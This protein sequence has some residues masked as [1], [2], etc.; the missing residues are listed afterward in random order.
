[1]DVKVI[2]LF[3]KGQVKVPPSKS[4]AH[5]ALICAALSGG[6]AAI[7]NIQLSKDI[8]ATLNCITALGAEYQIKDDTIYMRTGFTKK[9]GDKCVLD[10]NES[11]STLRFFIPIALALG[12]DADFIGAKRLFERPLTP[13]LECFKDKNITISKIENGVNVTG[14]LTADSYQ[15]KGNVSSQFIT[16]LL[17]ALP[18]LQQKSEIVITTNLESKGYVDLTLN[19][20]QKFG[21]EIKNNNYNSFEI[22][23]QKYIA[24]NTKVEGDYS[25]AAFMLVAAAL[26]CDIKIDG[27]SK[28]SLQ[29]DKKILDILQMAGADVEFDQNDIVSVTVQNKLTAFDI[30]VNEIPDLVPPIAVLMAF[31][32]GTSHILNASRLRIK[33][34]DRLNTVYLEL[35]KLGVIITENQDSLEITGQKTLIGGYCTGHNDHRIA[36]MCAVA[37]I[38]CK[39]RVNIQDYK[40]VDKSYPTFFEDFC[41]YKYFNQDK[42][43]VTNKNIVLIGLPG[44]GKTTIGRQIAKQFNMKFVDVDALIET[45]Q[46]IKIPQIFE[47]YGEEYFR[48]IEQKCVKMVSSQTNTVISTGGGVVTK[49]Q[50]MQYL[51]ENGIIIFIDRKA[52]DIANDIKTDNRPLMQNNENRIFE[53]ENQRRD[54]YLK[55]SNYV[56]ESEPSRNATDK[57]MFELIN[58]IKKPKR[59]YVIGDPIAHSLSPQIHTPVLQKFYNDASY[60]KCYVSK[61]SL[62][63][64]V[65]MVKQNNIKGFNIT[66]PHKAEIIKYLDTVDMAAQALNSVNT[67]VNTNG[68]L[69]GY[70]TDGKGFFT[71]LSDIGFLVQDKTVV[72]IGAGGAS[73]AV[74]DQAAREKAKQI[75]ILARKIGQAQA[76]EK[77]LSSIHTC[78]KIKPVQLDSES[79][80]K[81]CE[82][83]DLLINATSL[84]MHGTN[85]QFED[86][87]F[88]KQLPKTSVVADLI[89]KPDK[90]LFLQTAEKQGLKIMNG[91][92]MLIYQALIA[93]KYYTGQEIDFETMQ[94]VV[95]QNLKN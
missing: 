18:L 27:L 29:G 1:M 34:S 63:N 84:G 60:E 65:Y 50:N 22:Q 80:N 62:E 38:K 61:N 94:Q 28:A 45:T 79:L 52:K 83:A 82:K 55:Y 14:N 46:N 6:G 72:V 81:Y 95:K 88:I 17:F 71:A 11:G 85:A 37:A 53:L 68:K 15:I 9:N 35:S 39:S 77:T 16:G 51:A 8:L 47:K 59:Y 75:I 66:M 67:V 41:K 12:V 56:F 93:D 64:F 69:A 5:R 49:H 26:G 19:E 73:A 89:Y 23:N 32:E 70:S 87:S 42:Q 10:C 20:M 76:L 4:V 13:Y 3:P 33:E 36:M 48:E 57:K 44:C 43:A 7:K 90:T 24:T 92:G 25:N 30:D 21:V 86:L 74:C 91:L 78:T 40:C 54:L 58:E 31:C 2:D